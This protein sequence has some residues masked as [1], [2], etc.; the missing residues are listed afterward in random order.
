MPA[1]RAR[2]CVAEVLAVELPGIGNDVFEVTTQLARDDGAWRKREFTVD[3]EAISGYQRD[4]KE[5]WVAY[6]L[7]ESL[8]VYVVAPIS[9]RP[10]VIEL[11]T[12]ET[13]DLRPRDD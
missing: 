6:Y 9:L 5:M 4:F 1:D 10:D 12:L 11:H 8:I 3:G 7:T 13:S 2:E